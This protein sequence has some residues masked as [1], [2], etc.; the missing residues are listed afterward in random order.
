MGF[1]NKE[2]DYVTCATKLGIF[3]GSVHNK[4]LSLVP[5]QLRL[6]SQSLLWS[7]QGELLEYLLVEEVV[8]EILEV[9]V[10]LR[11]VSVFAITRQDAQASN[12]VVSGIVSVSSCAA[13]T[14]FD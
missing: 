8:V 2:P 7:L 3:E 11:Q 12:A 1:V 10:R 5:L 13:Y 6:V 9:A 4:H 14:L